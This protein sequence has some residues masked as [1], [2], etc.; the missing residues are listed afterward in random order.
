M[1]VCVRKRGVLEGVCIRRSVDGHLC[2]TLSHPATCTVS[3]SANNK[4]Q[5]SHVS[6]GWI[7]TYRVDICI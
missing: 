1:C 2:C 7:Y 3:Q 4:G 6:I 5:Y